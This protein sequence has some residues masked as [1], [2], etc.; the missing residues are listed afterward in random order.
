MHLEH[1]GKQF[2]FHYVI[3]FAQIETSAPNTNW[4]IVRIN[5]SIVLNTV[6]SVTKWYTYQP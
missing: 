5:N 2:Y 3:I 4:K 6:V 1:L